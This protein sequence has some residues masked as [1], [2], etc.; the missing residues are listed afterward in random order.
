MTLI[1]NTRYYC[2]VC[3]FPVKKGQQVILKRLC[4]DIIKEKDRI[5]KNKSHIFWR[6]Q[7]S[8]FRVNYMY[9]ILRGSVC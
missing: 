8:C 4:V 3:Q 9:I 6:R 5:S 1:F 2:S 7:R